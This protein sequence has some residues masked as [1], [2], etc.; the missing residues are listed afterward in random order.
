M[1]KSLPIIVVSALVIAII[2]YVL[3]SSLKADTGTLAQLDLTAPI[4]YQDIGSISKRSVNEYKFLLFNPTNQPLRILE[5]MTSC[6]CLTA[7]ITDG[8]GI[9]RTINASLQQYDLT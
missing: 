1:K 9:T 6:D 8:G 4:T 2:G 5:A 3:Y 7:S